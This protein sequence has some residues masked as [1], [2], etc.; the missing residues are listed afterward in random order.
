MRSASRL[1][2]APRGPSGNVDEQ[3]CRL[4]ALVTG[5]FYGTFDAICLV[6]SKFHDDD[7]LFE[8]GFKQWRKLLARQ[9][10]P[11]SPAHRVAGMVQ[12]RNCSDQK[13]RALQLPL[14]SLATHPLKLL[15]AVRVI[16]T[17]YNCLHRQNPTSKPY[18][19]ITRPT[20]TIAQLY[21]V[22]LVTTRHLEAVGNHRRPSITHPS[23][24]RLPI[25]SNTA[26]RLADSSATIARPIIQSS[27]AR[28]TQPEYH[29]NTSTPRC[30]ATS[31]S[32]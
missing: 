30:S 8:T 2:F 17:L 16:H 7:A 9:P 11:A 12:P 32:S 31:S 28:R 1:P 26:R 3:H 24:R 29:V 13:M 20:V 15:A 18:S 23:L 14:V 6:K 21:P 27:R 5:G 19:V 4:R 10:L 25:E 22:D